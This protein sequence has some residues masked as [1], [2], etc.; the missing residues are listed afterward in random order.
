MDLH[1]ARYIQNISQYDIQRET[2]VYQPVLSLF[3]NSGIDSLKEA[4]KLKIQKYLNMKKTKKLLDIGCGTGYFL[5][6]AELKG[7]IAYGIDISKEAIPVVPAAHYLCGGIQADLEGRTDIDGLYA[8]GETAFTGLHGA[9][10]LASNSLL[11]GLVFSDL[12]FNNLLQKER[13]NIEN[14]PAIP[15]WNPGSA[16]DSDESVVVSQNWD[17]IRRLMQNYVGIVKTDK[18]LERA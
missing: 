3:E 1:T 12:I 15:S 11:E 14:F 2:G 13:E 7:L 5:K 8:C 4:D 6:T 17:E 16:V 18:R 9:N 10:R